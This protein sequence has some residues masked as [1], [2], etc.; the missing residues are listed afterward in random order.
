MLPISLTSGDE[1]SEQVSILP[2]CYNLELED[3]WI[4]P[5]G[6]TE[7]I[8]PLQDKDAQER[9]RWRIMSLDILPGTS[10]PQAKCI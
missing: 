9:W 1:T 7:A 4:F 6:E 5:V 8:R 2:I 3:Y 10:F